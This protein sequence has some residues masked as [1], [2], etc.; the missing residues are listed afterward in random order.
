MPAEGRELT[1]YSHFIAGLIG[2]V[3]LAV[4]IGGLLNRE[5]LRGIATSLSREPGLILVLGALDLAVGLAI[6]QVHNLWVADWRVLVTLVGWFGLLRGLARTLAPAWLAA[7]AA[8]K[9]LDT[10]FAN[11][12]L[13]VT[14]AYGLVL[15]VCGYLL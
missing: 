4:G 7:H 6:L 2:P 1:G 9:L 13:A 5:A 11:V 3:A 10:G 8:P 12:A 15:T 14:A